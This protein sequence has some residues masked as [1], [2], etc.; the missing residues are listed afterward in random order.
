MDFNT[1]RY[2]PTSPYRDNETTKKNH[3]SN[4]F[5]CRYESINQGNHGRKQIAYCF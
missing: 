5:K 4:V 3:K 1:R 2:I